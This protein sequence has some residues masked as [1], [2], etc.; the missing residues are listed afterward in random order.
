VSPKR[1]FVAC[2]LENLV[3]GP[4]TA[5]MGDLAAEVYSRFEAAACTRPGDLVV[6]ATHPGAAFVAHR[7]APFARLVTRRGPDGADRRLIEELADLDRLSER[8]DQVVI[9]SGD[10]IFVE[11]VQALVGA[12][13]ETVVVGREA[14][15]AKR[16]QVAAHRCI[17]ITSVE[18]ASNPLVA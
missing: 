10:G 4:L 7:V 2:D 12:G 5:D 9:G 15:M 1:K 3:G 11:P 6:I 13:I 14:S 16:L 8:F 17:A 18:C